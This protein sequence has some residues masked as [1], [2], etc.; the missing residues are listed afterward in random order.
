[1]DVRQKVLIAGASSGIGK[2]T[3]I[4]FASEGWD[5]CLNAR[6]E[7]ML[8]EIQESL[9]AGD[10]L[11]CPG[12]FTDTAVIEAMRQTIQRDWGQLD[13][14]INSAGVY[15]PVD[16]I[17][18]P[19]EKWRQVFDI[20]INGAI[21]LARMAVPLVKKGGRIIFITSIHGARA[22][23]KASSYSMAKATLNQYARVLAVELAPKDILVNAI[24]P[25]FL[26]NPVSR[27]VGVKDLDAEDFRRDRESYIENN[28]PL[29]RAAQPEE[30]AG[31]AFFLAGPD[32]SYVTGQVLTVDGG[33][34]IAL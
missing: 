28:V 30:I 5:V 25:G 6:R 4:R 12:D 26:V 19:L 31:A 11:V 8:V 2:A 34:T 16:A 27:P 3:A 29:R 13:A 9:P 20:L 7:T 17:N 14:I 32:A 24:A 1:M 21:Y 33:L 22:T 18:D 23:V 15:A 10:H